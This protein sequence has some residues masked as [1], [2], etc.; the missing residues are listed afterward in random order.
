MDYKVES[1][2]IKVSDLSRGLCT[3]LPVMIRNKVQSSLANQLIDQAN[4]FYSENENSKQTYHKF[5][6]HFQK[7]AQIAK[8]HENSPHEM[9]RKYPP[10]PLS[11]TSS[12]PTY[13]KINNPHDPAFSKKIKSYHATDNP[14]DANIFAD[15][16]ILKILEIN[17]REFLDDNQKICAEYTKNGLAV[18][19]QQATRACPAGVA[20]ML[21]LDHDGKVDINSLKSTNLGNGEKVQQFIWEAGLESIKKKVE[22]DPIPFFKEALE[23]NGPFVIS[24]TERTGNHV[25]IVDEINEG[26]QTVSIRDPWHG[27]AIVVPIESFLLRIDPEISEIIQVK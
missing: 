14:S 22:G 12:A 11:D 26:D 5:S 13:K 20:A 23:T 18:V 25:I 1:P 4:S 19:Q 27:W 3:G 8:I 2:G 17:R 16:E 24:I 21:I 9:P 6:D 10:V 7:A 15:S